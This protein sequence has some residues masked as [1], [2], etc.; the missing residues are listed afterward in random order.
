MVASSFSV[1]PSSSRTPAS[2]TS[3]I[4]FSMVPISCS[5]D[6]RFRLIACAF[7]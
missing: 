4:S 7:F 2:S 3:L 1:A 6:A 5:S